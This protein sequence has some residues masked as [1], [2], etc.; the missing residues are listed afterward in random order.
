MTAGLLKS[1]GYLSVFWPISVM[2]ST[3]PLFSESLVP[4][5]I[6]STNYNWYNRHFDVPQFFQF[7][8]KVQVLIFLLGFFQFY[9]MVSWKSKVYNSTTKGLEKKKTPDD[10]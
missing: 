2:V 9:S 3:R 6:K 5:L 7:T 10:T 1:P 8:S 4:L